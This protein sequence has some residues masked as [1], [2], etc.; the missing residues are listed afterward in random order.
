MVQKVQE[1]M[2]FVYYNDPPADGWLE[3]RLVDDDG[4]VWRHKSKRMKRTR[5]EVWFDYDNLIPGKGYR[6]E[7]CFKPAS[8]TIYLNALKSNMIVEE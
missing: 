6:I 3:L 7:L 5:K 8:G 2:K 1:E 4:A